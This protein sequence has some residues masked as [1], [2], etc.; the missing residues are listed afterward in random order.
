M[1]FMVQ[2]IV[3]QP[4]VTKPELEVEMSELVM[5]PKLPRRIGSYKQKQEMSVLTNVIRPHVLARKAHN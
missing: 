4:E 2:K 1:F 5:T 3:Q